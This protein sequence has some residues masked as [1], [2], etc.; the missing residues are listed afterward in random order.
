M[1]T[2]VTF[3]EIM[4]RLT[5]PGRQRFS[6]ATGLQITYGG[7]EANVAAAL[8]QMGMSAAH[9]TVFPDNDLGRAAGAFFQKAGV[10]TSCFVY[11][12]GRLGLYFMEVGDGMRPSRIVYD[13][14]E[15]AFAHLDPAAFDWEKILSGA[16]WFHWTGITP[17]VSA[18]AAQACADAIAA[19]RKLGITV[20]TDVNYRRVLWKYGKQASEVMP[21]LVR[22]CDVAV[23]TE[24]DAADIFGIRSSGFV[25][26]AGK[27]KDAFP[28]LREIIATR[29]EVLSAS[30]NRLTGLCFDGKE[31]RES[32]T[33]ELNPIVDRIGG[34]DAFVAGYIYGS[35]HYDD[36]A[37]TLAFATAASALKHTIEGDYN[38]VG[39]QEVEQVMGG[40]VS[41][42]LLR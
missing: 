42:R 9:A 39:A 26:M 6:Q 19:A 31:Y 18:S 11:E 22:N 7:G 28:N 2:V 41:G 8:A 25:E 29:R 20:S 21:D 16:R 12:G 17:A 34:G 35:L 4:M 36:P 33:F 5:A 27:M 14:Y 23:C 3:G 37:K 30:H 40:D 13:R 1:P 32:P 15:S 38:L 10:D 24:G